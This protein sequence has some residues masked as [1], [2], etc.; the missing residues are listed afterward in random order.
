MASHTHNFSFRMAKDFLKQISCA[1]LAAAAA[2]NAASFLHYLEKAE[3]GR[4]R[5]A[6]NF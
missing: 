5:E 2:A 1:L 4:E 6:R 3:S